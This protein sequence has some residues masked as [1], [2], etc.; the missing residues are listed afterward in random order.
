M[1]IYFSEAYNETGVGFDTTRKAVRVARLLGERPIEGVCVVAP[2]AASFD[3]LAE[4]HDVAYLDAL[5]G[6]EP[7]S[8]AASN[9]IGWDPQLLAA[10]AA[11]TGGI[12]DAALA[13]LEEGRSG[14]LSSGLHHAKAG[15][16]HGYCTLNGLVVAARAAIGAGA[17]RVV[18][19]DAADELGRRRLLVGER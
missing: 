8:L 14:S 10:A 17:R 18:I 2:V 3:E 4:V 7:Y 5:V 15:K 13:A 19:V 6:G 9:G 11:S 16:G 12:R 1:R